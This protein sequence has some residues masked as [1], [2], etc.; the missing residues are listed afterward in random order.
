MGNN[1]NWK[2]VKYFMDM[3]NPYDPNNNTSNS[4]NYNDLWKTVRT[5][6]MLNFEPGNTLFPKMIKYDSELFNKEY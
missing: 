6:T 5:L 2:N 3:W 1:L 4:D